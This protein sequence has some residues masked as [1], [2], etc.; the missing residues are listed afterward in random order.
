VCSSDLIDS[1]GKSGRSFK[2]LLTAVDAWGKGD[3]PLKELL[4]KAETG[5]AARD[6]S[7]ASFNKAV[8]DYEKKYGV[9]TPLVP[10]RSN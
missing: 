6:E 9:T 5:E 2:E 1:Y 3:L 8:E 4:S 7:T 10:A